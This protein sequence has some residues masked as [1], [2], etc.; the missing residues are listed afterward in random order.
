MTASQARQGNSTS[1]VLGRRLGA[2]LLALRTAAGLTQ[3][4]AA[5]ALTAS[6]AK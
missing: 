5:K 1:S 2:E 3:P 4:Q 6:T